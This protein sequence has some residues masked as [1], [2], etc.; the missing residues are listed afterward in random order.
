MKLYMM[1]GLKIQ[2]NKKIDKK[3]FLPFKKPLCKNYGTVIER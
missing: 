2:N 1:F 3:H